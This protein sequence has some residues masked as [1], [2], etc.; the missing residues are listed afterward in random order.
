MLALLLG[1]APW[2]SALAGG[3]EVWA[4][5][6]NGRLIGSVDRDPAAEVAVYETLLDHLAEDDPL[7]SE[8]LYWLGRARFES[9]DTEGALAA[10]GSAATTQRQQTRAREYMGAVQMHIHAIE[11]IPHSTHFE[12]G[13]SHWVRGWN[14]GDPHDLRVEEAKGKASLCWEREVRQGED[15]FIALPFSAT[16]PMPRQIVMRMWARD[17]DAQIRVVLEDAQGHEWSAPVV[18]VPSKHWETFTFQTQDFV[19]VDAPSDARKHSQGLR[20]LMLRDMTGVNT[21]RRGQNKLYI[22]EV[23]IR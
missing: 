10:L 4:A 9:G 23:H 8:I 1:F 21:P 12:A 5:L 11:S 3:P 17:F 19:S 20:T 18:L 6:Y 22:S 14:R 16:T 2:T 13:Q 15:D 7:R